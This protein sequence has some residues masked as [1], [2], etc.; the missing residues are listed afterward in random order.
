MAHGKCSPLPSGFKQAGLSEKLH[1]PECNLGCT[2]QLQLQVVQ[3][4][5]C[6]HGKGLCWIVHLSSTMS[7]YPTFQYGTPRFD[8]VLF[9]NLSTT[10]YCRMS[11]FPCTQSNR[12]LWHVVK[13]FFTRDIHFLSLLTGLSVFECSYWLRRLKTCVFFILSA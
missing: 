4:Q 13:A 7:E 9:K 5:F 11:S 10:S 2:E 6:V 8:Q 1:Y 12:R 3:T